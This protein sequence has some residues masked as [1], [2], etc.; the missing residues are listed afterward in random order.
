MPV[1]DSLTVH[2]PKTR[3]VS[4]DAYHGPS[5]RKVQ[6]RVLLRRV[7]HVLEKDLAITARRA[8][9]ACALAANLD[10]KAA[11]PHCL[12]EDA[13]A[14]AKHPVVVAVQMEGVLVG[15]GAIVVNVAIESLVFTGGVTSESRGCRRVCVQ[16]LTLVNIRRYTWFWKTMSNTEL[17]GYLR[18]LSISLVAGEMP[19]AA[20]CTPCGTCSAEGC[21]AV[22]AVL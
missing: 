15:A 14:V 22:P 2:P 13:V 7:A 1:S 3:V 12:V 16:G 6:Q 21:H 17:S 20:P 11:V 9:V 19:S 10:V 18:I 8:R 5:T 4:L